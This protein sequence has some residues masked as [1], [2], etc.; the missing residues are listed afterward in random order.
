MGMYG[1]GYASLA[2]EDERVWVMNV[3]RTMM[4]VIVDLVIERT[5]D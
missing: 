4:T 5:K 1:D 3:V 2:M